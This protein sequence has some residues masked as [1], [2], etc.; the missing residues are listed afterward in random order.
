MLGSGNLVVTNALV[1]RR[2]TL[3]PRPPRERRDLHGR[4]LR[5]RDRRRRGRAASTRT[6]ADQ[7]VTGLTE[8]AKSRTPMLVLAGETPAAALTS[9]FRIDQHDL[10]ESVGAIADR[11]HSPKTAA[12]DAARAYQRA[13]D[14][15]APGRADAADRHPAAAGRP[16]RA[17]AAA[18]AAAAPAR[19]G[20]ARRSA[21]AADLLAE[22]Q[23]P[24]IIAGRGAVL[25]DAGAE[26]ERA[27]R[28]RS[29]RCWRRPRPPTACSRGSRT[30]SGSRAASR[31]PF[32]AEAAA[33]GRRRARVGASVDHWTTQA[34]R[35]D[36]PRRHG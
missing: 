31:R 14:R 13:V 7:H 15:A 16:D 11:V 34:R 22:A 1:A 28:S 35:D 10:V 19:A 29:G 18:T 30:R 33:P 26:L 27:R 32:A 6:R 23:R 21:N 8:A 20:A 9:N 25:A 3:P 17:L 4:R 2:R 5:A 12:D 24:A 36:R